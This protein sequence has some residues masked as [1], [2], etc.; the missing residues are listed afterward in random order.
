MN[1]KISMSRHPSHAHDFSMSNKC[2]RLTLRHLNTQQFLLHPKGIKW[3]RSAIYPRRSLKVLSSSRAARQCKK[4][5]FPISELINRLKWNFGMAFKSGKVSLCIEVVVERRARKTF[6]NLIFF[7]GFCAEE[8]KMTLKIF[9]WWL[10]LGK[11]AWCRGEKVSAKG[12]KGK[13]RANPV[14]CQRVESAQKKFFWQSRKM[15][16]FFWCFFEGLIR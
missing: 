6:A 10:R 15:G 12:A 16:K 1:G 9:F 8:F 11:A 7:P 4:N 2:Y 14:E 13:S 3:E 5:H